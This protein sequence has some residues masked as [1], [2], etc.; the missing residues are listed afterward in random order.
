MEFIAC[1]VGGAVLIGC[2]VS[3]FCMPTP[4]WHSHEA[5]AAG[6][7]AAPRRS[8]FQRNLRFSNNSLLI[9]IGAIIVATAFVPHGRAWMLL[10]T[11]IL[12]LLL[13]CILLAMIDAMSSLAGYRQA[14]PEAARR[15][16]GSDHDL[17]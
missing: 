3:L 11:A 4:N 2:G 9:S 8:N 16:L 17:N 12:V 1:I 6:P 15:S 14:L 13:I 10:W 5:P 7:R